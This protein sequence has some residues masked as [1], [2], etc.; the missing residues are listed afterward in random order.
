MARRFA[1]ATGLAVLFTMLLG[2]ASPASAAKKKRGCARVSAVPQAATLPQ[3]YQA[4]LCL[5]NQERA[6]RR[7]SRLRRSAE[8]TQAAVG[9]STDMVARQYFAHE[10]LEGETAQQRV[11]R[12]GYFQGGAGLVEESLACGWMQLSTPKALV[13]SL[14]RSPEHQ[15]IL[16]SRNVRD[17]GI[18][19]V[20][21]GPQPGFPGGATLTL[22]FARR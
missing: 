20:L 9:H 3:A 7:L 13:A 12:S 11:L 10:S 8:L 2:G 6:R 22:D 16:L 5:I 1:I 15:S 18:G 21:G 19:L 17:V 14:M 4:V